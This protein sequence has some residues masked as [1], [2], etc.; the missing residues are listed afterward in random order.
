MP[1]KL[2]TINSIPIKKIG[3]FPRG[4]KLELLLD[5]IV[6]EFV[7]SIEN[8]T[9]DES[10]PQSEI[11]E[12]KSSQIIDLPNLIMNRILVTPDQIKIY[13]AQKIYEQLYS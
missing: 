6:N 12:I 3:V 1:D 7:K 10:K 2:F 9:L 4:T 11:D 8:L 13:I 5:N